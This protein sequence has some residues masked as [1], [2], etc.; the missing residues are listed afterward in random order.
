MERLNEGLPMK[1]KEQ[2]VYE[3]VGYLVMNGADIHSLTI[4]EIADKAGIGKGT[5]YEYVSSKE[6][7]VT[8]GMA[9]CFGSRVHHALNEVRN[10]SG[11][12]S[13]MGVVLDC[14]DSI[15][16]CESFLVHAFQA[17][18]IVMQTPGRGREIGNAVFP[19]V[20]NLLENLIEAARDDG[21]IAGNADDHCMFYALISMFTG[22]SFLG[23]AHYL[24]NIKGDCVLSRGEVLETM[25]SMLRGVGNSDGQ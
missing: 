21:L 8:K 14:L 15:G 6:E 17:T 2:A 1:T 18:K 9:Y 10:A 13:K 22:Y 20:R 24:E 7:L 5:V 19:D 11:F 12:R 4:S 16:K 25:C 3:A 23:R